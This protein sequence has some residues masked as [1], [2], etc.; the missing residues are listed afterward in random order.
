MPELN[1][2]TAAPSSLDRL[3]DL[4]GAD[5]IL[6][7][8]PHR[9]KGPAGVTGW[10]KWTAEDTKRAEC[11]G[12]FEGANIAVLLGSGLYAIDIDDDTDLETFFGLNPDLRGTFT[13]RGQR[14]AKM[15]VHADA[16]PFDGKD[17]KRDGGTVCEV[18]QGNATIG[19]THPAG[20]E[21]RDNGKPAMPV[22]WESIR[23]PDGWEL[24]GREKREPDVHR[25]DP[26]ILPS[27]EEPAI[28]PAAN[29]IFKRISGTKTMFLRGGRV[30]ELGAGDD[31]GAVL[32][33]V[34]PAGFCS[35]LEG[36]GP[37]MKWVSGGKDSEP[38]LKPAACSK[39]LAEKLIAAQEVDLLPRITSIVTGPVPIEKEGSLVPLGDGFHDVDS[40]GGILVRGS[41]TPK[42]MT[43][44]EAV[45]VIV[46]T[47]ADFRFVTD[48]DRARA[49]AFL[50]SPV[51]KRV[52]GVSFPIF[53]VEAADSQT[54]K[55]YLVS[56]V[57]AICGERPSLVGQ[58]NGGVGGF[59][60]SLGARLIEGRPFILFDNLRGKI[61]S[62]YLEMIL[63]APGAVPCRIPHR[64][65]ISIDVTG[66]TFALTSN[67]VETTRDLANRANVIRLR[68]REDGRFTEYSEG[69]LL[70]H[71]RANRGRF[72]G[73]V[74]TVMA[75][76]IS[77]GKPLSDDYRGPGAFRTWWRAV[78]YICREILGTSSPLD[79]L[80]AAAERTANPSLQWLREICLAIEGEERIGEEFSGSG[81]VDLSQEHG[82]TVPGMR[83]EGVG[84]QKIVGGI[85][86]RIFKDDHLHQLDDW[87]ISRDQKEVP[88]ED[89]K[90]FREM[91]FYTVQ[92][93]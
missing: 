13:V 10:Q 39:E 66:F 14:G 33:I 32:E 38:M 8:C 84:A 67:G 77:R 59:D 92:K 54:G 91:N 79:G 36:Y 83:S 53:I 61:D 2:A 17:I 82:L 23:W 34:S 24:P 56:T 64:G 63:T 60:E 3:R 75:E 49:V 18:L 21:Y 62:A 73:A 71:I 85:M 46:E 93:A 69:D 80:Q 40:G 51:T 20:M 90:G 6:I 70:E 89:G 22:S 43:L 74:F 65:E 42:A 15:I 50:L 11:D 55:G 86:K 1:T 28:Q 47:L 72:I 45:A 26:I 68:K 7:P 5:A 27:S 41:V 37:V 88:R 78:D 35:R 9:T 12:R 52:I 31:G 81:L 30:V 57:A 76:W 87:T 19:G 44:S 4:L 16:P 25:P 58:R 48:S 29:S